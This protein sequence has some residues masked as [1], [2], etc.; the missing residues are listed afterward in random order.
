[1]LT[2]KELIR[3]VENSLKN[4][5]V[6]SIYEHNN[7]VGGMGIFYDSVLWK[8]NFNSD[9]IF[10]IEIFISEN[11]KI[12]EALGKSF[13]CLG[14]E[15]ISTCLQQ[16]EDYC[17]LLLPD[18]FLEAY[19]KKKIERTQVREPREKI[20]FEQ[21]VDIAKNFWGNRAKISVNEQK[22]A[23][24]VLYDAFIFRW[25]YNDRYGAFEGG[26]LLKNDSLVWDYLGKN[27]QTDRWKGAFLKDLEIVDQYC[28]M[29][30][31]D[32]YLKAY[33]VAYSTL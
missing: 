33:D 18:K 15:G 32:K 30:L 12:K 27:L 20:T 26:V 2:S 19:S 14:T 7:C 21:S 25:N 28:R 6:F 10:W 9:N 31:P 3:L 17:R 8:Y 29:R 24:C 23:I 11:Y 16:V 5:F 4:G 1:M 22:E 13:C